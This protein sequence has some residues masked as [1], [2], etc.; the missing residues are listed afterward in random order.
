MIVKNFIHI[1]SILISLLLFSTLVFGIPY[2]V[3]ALLQTTTKLD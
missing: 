2:S 1:L 3:T